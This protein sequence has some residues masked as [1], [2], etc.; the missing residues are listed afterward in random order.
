MADSVSGSQPKARKRTEAEPR[1]TN[2]TPTME[3]VIETASE[4]WRNDPD[5][6]PHFVEDHEQ[7]LEEAIAQA[8]R[9]AG[10]IHRSEVLSDEAVTALVKTADALVN[11][12]QWG[13]WTYMEDPAV[14][15]DA[16]RVRE[17]LKPFAALGE[18]KGDG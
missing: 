13:M 6:N 7:S 5:C 3:E 14:Y 15:S 17:A 4:A 2:P 12:E 10:F 9:Q 11:H 18:E 1:H 8:L 16:D